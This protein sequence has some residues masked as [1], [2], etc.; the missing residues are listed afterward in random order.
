MPTSVSLKKGFVSPQWENRYATLNANASGSFVRALQIP[1]YNI[2][3]TYFCANTTSAVLQYDA[4]CDSHMTLPASGI[5]GTFGPGSCGRVI[6]L[7]PTGTATAGSTTAVT[8]NLTINRDLRGFKIRITG[9]PGSGDERI[10]ASN[11]LGA[12]SVITIAA[13]DA[14]SAAITASSTYRLLTPR[15]WVFN[16][17]ATPGFGYWDYALSAWT[18]GLSVSGLT[19]TATDGLMVSTNSLTGNQY[20]FGDDKTFGS[21]TANTLSLANNIMGTP[22]QGPGYALQGG[23]TTNQWTGSVIQIVGGTGVGQV[24]TIASNT[25]TTITVDTNWGVNPDATS[26]WVITK[27]FVSSRG[28]TFSSTTSSILTVTGPNWVANT[29]ANFQ[30]RAISGTGAGQ[31]RT[32]SSNTS[33]TITVGTTWTTNFD[34]TTV[35]VI[36]GNDD[37]IYLAGN[38]AVALFKYTISGATWSTVSPTAA[39]VAAPGVGFSMNWITGVNDPAWTAGNT[40]QNGRYIYSFRASGGNILDIFDTALVTW[41]SGKAYGG[42]NEVFT[43]GNCWEYDGINTIYGAMPT[44]RLIKFDVLK[45]DLKPLASQP[46]Y[47]QGAATVGDKLFRYS[48]QDGPTRLDFLYFWGNTVS[49]LSRMLI[50]QTY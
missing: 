31:I 5:A 27:A 11:T 7:G 19:F 42:Q 44:G 23:W 49:N 29:L 14:F 26:K 47:T 40:L 4:I 38:G 21:S 41:T 10:I 35:W 43:T 1:A 37:S 48:F 30:I 13:A 46:I 8:T 50:F 22:Q 12:N 34:A 17:A 28:N 24:R 9:G 36:E 2:D 18:A 45:N 6:P 39:R 16:P 33:A 20:E 3:A 32:I 15:L 25:Q